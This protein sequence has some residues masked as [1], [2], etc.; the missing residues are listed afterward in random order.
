MFKVG[1]IVRFK[2]DTFHSRQWPGEFEVVQV[3]IET[4]KV[5]R[6]EDTYALGGYY[7]HRFELAVPFDKQASII[8]KIKY[9]NTRYENR[10]QHATL[11]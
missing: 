2:P 10:E 7:H 3:G 8:A 11:G 6:K 1:D 5:K 9:L 4:T